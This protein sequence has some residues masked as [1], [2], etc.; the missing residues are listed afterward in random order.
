MYVRVTSGNSFE[1]REVKVLRTNDVEAALD[2]KLQPGET[3]I[4]GV[5]PEVIPVAASGVV[6]AKQ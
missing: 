2:A 6:T 4:R 5:A 1:K 3:V